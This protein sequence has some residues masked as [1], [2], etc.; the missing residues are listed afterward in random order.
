MPSRL[1]AAVRRVSHA[2]ELIE[3]QRG[4][5]EILKANGLPTGEAE[6]L[7]KTYIRMLALFEELERDLREE[8]RKQKN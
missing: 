5:I 8:L 7:L 1:I 4:R 2:K 6:A 3:R